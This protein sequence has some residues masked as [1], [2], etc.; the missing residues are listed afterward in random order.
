LVEEKVWAIIFYL[1]CLRAMEERPGLIEA[2]KE[3]A[4]L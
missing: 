2:G 4:R 1:A 3:A